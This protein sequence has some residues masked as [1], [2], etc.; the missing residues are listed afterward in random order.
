[1]NP[2]KSEISR[3]LGADGKG[4]S[5]FGYRQIKSSAELAAKLFGC[6][7]ARKIPSTPEATALK[8]EMRDLV[9]SQVPQGHSNKDVV[10][11]RYRQ[12]ALNACGQ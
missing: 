3:M 8:Q 12:Y 1:M 9:M 4:F 5:G 2:S 7:W 10:W 6:E 11:Q